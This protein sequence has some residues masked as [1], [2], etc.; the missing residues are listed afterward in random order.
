MV[1]P[2]DAKL[3]I[4]SLWLPFPPHLFNPTLAPMHLAGRSGAARARDLSHRLVHRRLEPCARKRTPARRKPCNVQR[5]VVLR[6]LRAVG[7]WW[8]EYR[9]C[10]VGQPKYG[11]GITGSREAVVIGSVH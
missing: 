2:H 7:M 5:V 11:L 4:G 3:S 10:P 6:L 9:Y 1:D 8:Q